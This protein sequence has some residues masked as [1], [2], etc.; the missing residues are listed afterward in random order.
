[1]TALTRPSA[2]G[3]SRWPVAQALAWARPENARLLLATAILTIP[4]GVGPLAAT[5][6]LASW[7]VVSYLGALLWAV[8]RVARAASDWLRATPI[9]FWSFAWPLARRMLLHQLGGT[10][11][12]VAVMLMLGTAPSTAVYAGTVWL[13][14]VVLV[15]TLSFAECYRAR[16][17]VA[18]ITLSML[19]VLLAEQRGRGW[20]ISLAILLAALHMRGGTRHARA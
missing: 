2:A 7:I 10:L 5:G 17:P 12:G 11:I 8:P 13:T 20:G 18:K 1:V 16:S 9:T 15:T 3:L 6:L 14:L 19:A 4:G